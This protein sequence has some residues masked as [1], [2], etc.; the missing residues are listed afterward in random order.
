MRQQHLHQRLIQQKDLLKDLSKDFIVYNDL[1]QMHSDIIK[2]KI[3]CGFVINDDLSKYSTQNFK[4]Y[5]VDFLSTANNNRAQA[6][7][8]VFFDIMY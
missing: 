6:Y 2:N 5:R 4:D 7:K 3:I 8:E 1:E